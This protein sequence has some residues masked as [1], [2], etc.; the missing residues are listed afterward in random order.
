[1]C[2]RLEG[3][4]T[5]EK[6]NPHGPT[7]SVN[8]TK[9]KLGGGLSVLRGSCCGSDVCAQIRN[10]LGI[11]DLLSD[12]LMYSEIPSGQGLRPQSNRM[13]STNFET[14]SAMGKSRSRPSRSASSRTAAKSRSRPSRSASSRT[15]AQRSHKRHTRTLAECRPLC[16]LGVFMQK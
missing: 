7:T 6:T 3:V 16:G 14:T 5:E 13:G 12:N 4:H 15:A 9:A 1:M 2:A 11:C 10:A 8:Y